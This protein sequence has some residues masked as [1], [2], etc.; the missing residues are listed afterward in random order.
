MLML[1]WADMLRNDG[2][3]CFCISPGFLA[4][5]LAGKGNEDRLKA[6]GA[7]EPRL[8]GELMRE[9]VEGRRDGDAGKVVNAGGI[10]A[11]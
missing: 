7:G 3:K 6:V 4:T 11:W 2:V 1:Q 5:G 9:V 10:Q 8:G